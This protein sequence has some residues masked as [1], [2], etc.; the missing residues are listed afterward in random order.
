MRLN[1]SCT[2]LLRDGQTDFIL[3]LMFCWPCLIV[4][5]YSKT[6]VM[7]FLFNLLRIK[8]L[9]N[10]R[11]LLAHPQEVL[12]KQHL[13][14]GVRVMSVACPRSGV[15]LVPLIL[16]KLNKKCITL[17]SL[18]WFILHV[19][20]ISRCT[21]P[22]VSV[23]QSG[24]CDVSRTV[25]QVITWLSLEV[26]P[27][28]LNPRLDAVDSSLKLTLK[29]GFVPQGLVIKPDDTLTSASVQILH[30]LLYWPTPPIPKP[31]TTGSTA[32]ITYPPSAKDTSACTVTTPWL[33]DSAWARCKMFPLENLTVIL[34]VP[35]TKTLQFWFRFLLFPWRFSSAP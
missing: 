33:K 7:H 19:I 13:V 8:G 26:L 14:D 35:S 10:F 17:V 21:Q 12:H 4:Y 2:A 11:A 24:R 3:H 23:N 1:A 18:Y 28:F 25:K 15:E 20:P 32:S 30:S 27:P 22:S 6:N 9:Y 29:P 31:T 16:N 5:Q 34:F